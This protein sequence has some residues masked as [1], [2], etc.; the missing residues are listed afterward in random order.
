MA[1]KNGYAVNF[2]WVK[3]CDMH[4]LIFLKT[5]GSVLA[6]IRQAAIEDFENKKTLYDTMKTIVRAHT[7]KRKCFIQEALYYI[8]SC[9][10]FC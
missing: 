3:G 9:S 1:R 7:S 8:F 5:W 6:S 10:V 2:T 4:V